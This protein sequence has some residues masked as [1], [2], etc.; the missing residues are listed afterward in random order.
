MYKT[1]LANSFSIQMVREYSKGKPINVNMGIISLEEVKR[2]INKP[3]E[4]IVS[5]IGHQDTA[6][7]VSS[8]LGI[9]VPCNRTSIDLKDILHDSL[10]VFQI[11]GG[12]L[13]EGCTTLPEGIEIEIW[14]V[15]IETRDTRFD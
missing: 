6:R 9:D 2:I 12:R 13:P 15:T 14:L 8:M 4:E 7:F 11:V 5:C 10:I 1:Y 3:D